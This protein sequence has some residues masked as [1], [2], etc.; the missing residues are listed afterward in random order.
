MKKTSL[1]KYLFI[2]FFLQL[3]LL[4]KGQI[5][6]SIIGNWNYS[7]PTNDISEAGSDF[8][9]TYSSSSNAVTVDVFQQSWFANFF[10]YNWRVDIRRS[11]VDW[12]SNLQLYTRR[13]GNGSP[14]FFNG[15][16]S[17]GTSY[18]QITNTNQLF[19]NGNR[20]RLDIP[21]QYEIRNVSVLIPAKT[22]ETTIIY[23]V[24]EL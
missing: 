17:G 5:A 22:Y 6:I 12:H 19:F 3:N 1:I 9:G 13:T 15:N 24:T 23:T 21:I 4:A 7:I 20:T 18:Q 2:V 8:S 16:I 10:N 14:F 11:D